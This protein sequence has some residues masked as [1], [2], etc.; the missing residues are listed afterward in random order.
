YWCQ[1]R[2]EGIT[3][4]VFGYYLDIFI[5]YEDAQVGAK[6]TVIN[7]DQWENAEPPTDE[8]IAKYI[9]THLFFLREGRLLQVVDGKAGAAR[10]IATEKNIFIISYFIHNSKK[11]IYYTGRPKK[12]TSKK[13]LYLYDFSTSSN[14]FLIKNIENCVFDF[15]EDKAIIL[16]ETKKSNQ[17]YWQFRMFDLSNLNYIQEI[18]L[19]KKN[20]EQS[21]DNPED[22]FVETML[23]ESGSFN[24]LDWDTKKKILYFKPA[25]DNQ[26]YLIS[27]TNP[28]YIL[29]DVDDTGIFE[30]DQERFLEI[31]LDVNEKNQPL[32][33][34]VLKNNKTGFEKEVFKSVYYPLNFSLS[35]FG[36]FI[37]VTLITMKTPKEAF[38]P[39]SIYVFSLKNLTMIPVSTDGESYQPRWGFF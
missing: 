4:W 39:A 29:V 27:L 35:P 17:I 24:K 6:S 20:I 15:T 26:T 11:I 8:N 1:I 36:N 31:L 22:I 25:E 34:I 32:Y 5:N 21:E 37:A 9:N 33:S 38:Y 12:K 28:E 3:G 23:R 16:T 18:I 30:I 7:S 19:I 14:R 13:S 2:F 10:I